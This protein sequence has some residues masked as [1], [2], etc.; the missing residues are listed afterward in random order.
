[1]SLLLNL[2]SLPEA[3]IHPVALNITFQCYKFTGLPWNPGWLFQLHHYLVQTSPSGGLTGLPNTTN[4]KLILHF[5]AS[6][7]S[8]LPLSPRSWHLRDWWFHSAG[9]LGQ[10]LQSLCWFLSF[11]Y[12]LHVVHEKIPSSLLLEIYSASN[13]LSFSTGIAPYSPIP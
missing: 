7:P 9:C 1:M 5:P 10:K 11:S 8:F 13:L 4:A 6:C 2:H 3:L 12:A